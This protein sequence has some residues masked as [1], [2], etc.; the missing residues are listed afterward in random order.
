M[1]TVRTPTGMP[2]AK[3]Q[4]QLVVAEQPTERRAAR[5]RDRRDCAPEADDRRPLAGGK[6]ESSRPSAAEAVGRAAEDDEQ[7]GAGERVGVTIHD[8]VPRLVPLKSSSIAGKAMLTIV[9]SR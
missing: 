4:R 7:R 8:S 9:T 3:I 2:M 6:L 5:R 1:T